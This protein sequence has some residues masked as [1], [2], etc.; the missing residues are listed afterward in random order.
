MNNAE[1]KKSLVRQKQFKL[2][3]ISEVSSLTTI[4][5]SHVYKLAREGHFPKP[6]KISTHSSVWLES[7]V[8]AWMEEKLGVEFLEIV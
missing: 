6:R 5:K 4:S 7:E 1:D 2:I 3:R 8:I